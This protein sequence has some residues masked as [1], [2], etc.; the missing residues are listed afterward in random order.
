MQ[1]GRLLRFSKSPG[2]NTPQSHLPDE[3]TPR[4]N[5]RFVCESNL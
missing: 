5:T 4:N 3:Y 1:K 2:E